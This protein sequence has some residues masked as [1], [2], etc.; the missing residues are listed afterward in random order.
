MVVTQLTSRK[1]LGINQRT[2]QRLK[3]ALTLNLRRQLLIAVCDNTVLQNQLAT[4]LELDIAQAKTAGKRAEDALQSRPTRLAQLSLEAEHPD[5]IKQVIN[6][7]QPQPQGETPSLQVLGIEQMTRQSLMLQ[8][9]FF[10]SLDKID[11]LLPRLE[12]SLLIW[13]PWPWFRAIQQ[14]APNFW[15]WRSGVF[16]FVSDPS[17][18][19]MTHIEVGPGDQRKQIKF[20]HT[21]GAPS[22][23]ADQRPAS[24][25]LSEQLPG[26][27][28]GDLGNGDTPAAQS[29]DQSQAKPED[30]EAEALEK[31]NRYESPKVDL[32]KTESRNPETRNVTAESS[33]SDLWTL[34][35]EDLARL[36]RDGI[37][38]E[39][40]LP[41]ESSTAE[42]PPSESL[43]S[44]GALPSALPT[45]EPDEA[46]LKSNLDDRGVNNAS[47]SAD[48]LD[49][50]SAQELPQSPF[51][52]LT[53]LK[54]RNAPPEET[55]QAYLALGHYYR[56]QIESGNISSSLIQSAAEA[57]E[58]GLR[59]LPE[60]DPSWGTGLND[61]GTL[62][63][64]QAQQQ[65]S[66]DQLLQGMRHSL[67][68]YKQ[69]LAKVNQKLQPEIA[70]RLHSNL[71]AVHSTLAGYNDAVEHLQQSVNSYRQA[72][73]FCA[74]EQQPEEYA[75][76]QNSL[77]SVYWKLSH[78]DQPKSCLHRAIA[79]YNESLRCRHP[80]KAPLDY[81]AV[82]N[83]LGIAYWSLA[84]HERPIFLLKHAIAAYRDALNYRTPN[85]DP[86]ACASTYN[87]LGTAYWELAGQ[88]DAAAD[89][90]NRYQQ[91]AAIAYEAALKAAEQGQSNLDLKSIHHCL[92]NV[93]EQLAQKEE[94]TNVIELQMQ[95]SLNH[96][97]AAIYQLSKTSP[98]YEPIFSSLVRNVRNHY[99]LLSTAGQQKALNQLP[100]HLLP[101][102][103][104][105]L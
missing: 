96:H 35:S 62:Y 15:Q 28:Y 12:S 34:L 83:N 80:E 92:G 94:Q 103:M 91:N 20:T 64:M 77:G 95:R 84:K 57:Y 102:V 39:G 99:E 93:Y 29:Q 38:I 58:E 61:L 63:W 8:H 33:S 36:E 51:D 101:E 16:E 75:T 90:Q 69:G 18:I 25:Q 40:L 53:A 45:E 59:W 14:S 70:S 21:D 74:P 30:S 23:T 86:A 104:Q 5:L 6:W 2:Y 44:D 31:R 98:N 13:L 9:H 56:E 42:T 50:I 71:G 79:A 47:P 81:A 66:R 100:A 1:I 7:L 73:P 11:R 49:Q 17:P 3:V 105:S 10:Q 52:R 97:L 60:E 89:P 43:G 72:L 27:L 32:H 87:N 22:K 55:A 54:R 41:S 82:Q 26:K 46:L 85:T 4:Q 68:I 78:Y 19:G 24:K 88:V 48:E 67:E 65:T 76:L 37:D